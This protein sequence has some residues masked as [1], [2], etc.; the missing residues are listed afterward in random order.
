MTQLSTST[1]TENAIKVIQNLS[2][3]VVSLNIESSG[4]TGYNHDGTT[5]ET[6]GSGT[7]AAE[8]SDYIYIVTNNHLLSGATHCTI[9]IDDVNQIDASVVGSDASKDLAVI[10]VGKSALKSAG[11][12][13][14]AVADFA[15]SDKLQVGQ[16]VI[17]IGNSLGEG[18]CATSGIISALN[19]EIDL[20]GRSM[21]MVQTDAAI[22]LGNSGGP[23]VDASSQVVAINTAK[24][25]TTADGDGTVEG[26]SYSIPANTVK[27]TVNSIINGHKVSATDSDPYLGVTGSNLSSNYMSMTG[28]TYG[29]YVNSVASNS[30]ASKA[31]IK[32]GDIITTFNGSS[33]KSANDITTSLSKC[34]IGQTIK[35]RIYRSGQSKLL[36]VTL[37]A[38]NSDTKF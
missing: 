21:K 29:V 24:Y 36:S 18:K 12:T 6:A 13:N 28:L 32:A 20:S 38:N 37:T 5:Y 25:Q 11:I 14:Y 33:V 3:E 31:G 35:I 8:D 2:N 1:I 23:L 19:K 22:N 7:I 27:D 17:A 15:D 4:T 16:S 26:M 30:P 34:S 10:K 9:S